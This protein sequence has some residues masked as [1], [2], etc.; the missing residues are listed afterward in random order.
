MNLKDAG[1]YDLINIF[2]GE[3]TPAHSAS[4]GGIINNTPRVINIPAYQRPYRWGP[5]NISRLFQDYAENRSEYFLG[6]AVVVEMRKND[7]SIEFDVVD[8]QQ[9]TKEQ[10][11]TNSLTGNAS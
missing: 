5:D 11:I 1:I 4:Q 7:G 8:G 10:K 6:S 9:R 2:K 3:G